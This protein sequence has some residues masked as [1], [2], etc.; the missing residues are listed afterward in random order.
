MVVVVVVVLKEQWKRKWLRAEGTVEEEA[1]D[2][3]AVRAEGMAEEEAMV[4]TGR[5]ASFCSLAASL[6]SKNALCFNVSVSVSVSV[7]VALWKLGKQTHKAANLMHKVATLN[8]RVAIVCSCVSSGTIG[9]ATMLV[10]RGEGGEASSFPGASSRYAREMQSHTRSSP[11]RSARAARDSIALQF[12]D[13]QH[14][15]P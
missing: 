5:A 6:S 14:Q 4:E 1:L 7:G 3:A 12:L 11:V 15:I 2:E 10:V 13:T 8:V 9:K